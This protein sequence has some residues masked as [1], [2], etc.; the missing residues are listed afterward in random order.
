MLL[1]HVFAHKSRTFLARIKKQLQVVIWCNASIAD[2]CTRSPPGDKASRCS[3]AI[4]AYRSSEPW[5][6]LAHLSKHL[7]VARKGFGR[8]SATSRRLRHKMAARQAANPSRPGA[9]VSVP[10]LGLD[11][12]LLPAGPNTF[13]DFLAPNPMVLSQRVEE[14]AQANASRKR[15]LLPQNP[16]LNKYK[17][18]G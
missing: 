18:N 8:R 2:R 13:V 6:R 5:Y 15:A 4:V 9:R 1:T 10:T 7:F 17:W 14:L 3:P 12:G 16:H 11:G